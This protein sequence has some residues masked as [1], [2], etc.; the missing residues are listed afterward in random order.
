MMPAIRVADLSKLTC[1]ASTTTGIP[2]GPAACGE[3][4]NHL[5]VQGLLVEPTLAGDDHVRELEVVGQDG[6]GRR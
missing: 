4:P 2:N 1:P 5:S 6:C 3:L